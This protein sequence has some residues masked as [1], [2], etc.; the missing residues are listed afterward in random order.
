MNIDPNSILRTRDM[1][2][3]QRDIIGLVY[4]KIKNTP[5]SSAWNEFK[6]TVIYKGRKF[7]IEMTY[8][9]NDFFLEI[10]RLDHKEA[11]D[12]IIKPKYIHYSKGE[13]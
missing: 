8:R 7:Q 11:P 12:K 9:F 2:Q 5:K 6:E 4:S 1:N 13:R 3:V 10:Q